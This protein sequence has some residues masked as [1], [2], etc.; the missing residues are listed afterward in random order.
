M[1]MTLSILV[2]GFFLRYVVVYAGQVATAVAA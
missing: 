2:G 1:K